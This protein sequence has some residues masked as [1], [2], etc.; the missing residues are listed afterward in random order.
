MR[1]RSGHSRPAAISILGAGRVGSALA[2]L[3]TDAGENVTIIAS[4]RAARAR[5]AAAFGGVPRST[6]DYARAAAAGDRVVLAVVDDALPLVVERLAASRVVWRGKVVLHTS[7]Y[8]GAEALGILAAKGAKVGTLHPLMA[9]ASPEE[10]LRRIPGAA[11]AVDGA[12]KAVEIAGRLARAAGGWA[13]RVPP[14]ARPS[15]HASA[16][17][18]ANC[19]VALIDAAAEVMQRAGIPRRLA[20]A[21]LTPLT[22]GAVDNVARLGPSRG[23][24][25]PVARGDAATVQGH[26]QVLDG[27]VEAI[28][29]ALSRRMIALADRVD[30]S[31][32]R[33]AVARVLG[34]PYP[35]KKRRAVTPAGARGAARATPAPPARSSAR[36]F[37]RR[38]RSRR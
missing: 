11:F 38:A 20:L 37:P 29:R 30:P 26:L 15:Y 36:S 8:H 1:A 16:V 3:W 13:L 12:P 2:R 34:P 17:L 35:E 21:A 19:L 5:A 25:G 24:T 4:R 22:R 32:D 7:G 10:G 6:G 28:Y 23:L 27:D 33:R 14:A 9:V 31:I 18:A